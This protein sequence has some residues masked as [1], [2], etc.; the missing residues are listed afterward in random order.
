MGGRRLRPVHLPAFVLGRRK[1]HRRQSAVHAGADSAGSV[2]RK[3]RRR[4]AHREHQVS[5]AR[6][7]RQRRSRREAAGLRA[8]H[9]HGRRGNPHR[10]C[11]GAGPRGIRLLQGFHHADPRDGGNDCLP[12]SAAAQDSRRRAHRA[13]AHPRADRRPGKDS[14]RA[15]RAE[16]SEADQAL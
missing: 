8:G 13:A 12:H 9:P 10:T 7:P 3:A 11:D 14:H 2:P 5:Y 1:A 6:L 15:A 4:G 16:K